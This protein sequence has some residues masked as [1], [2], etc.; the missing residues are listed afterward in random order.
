M[1]DDVLYALS[2][3]NKEDSG[4]FTRTPVPDFF[5]TP[6]DNHAYSGLGLFSSE[7]LF[8]FGIKKGAPKGGAQK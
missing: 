2:F 4:I 1:I 5:R 7:I 3:P 6:A 8:K